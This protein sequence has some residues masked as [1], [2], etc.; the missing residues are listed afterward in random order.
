[1]GNQLGT[2]IIGIVALIATA[3]SGDTTKSPSNYQH[4]NT[5][6]SLESMGCKET[7]TILK[8]YSSTG[9]IAFEESNQSSIS[10]VFKFAEQ[11]LLESEAVP[12][13]FNK[14]F[15]DN[16]WNLLA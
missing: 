7:D 4:P 2:G 15:N 6:L 10:I 3:G 16:F 13:E 9:E 8:G 1:M 14:T 11:L 12:S 5:T